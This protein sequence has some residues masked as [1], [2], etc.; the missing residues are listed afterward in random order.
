VYYLD[1]RKTY[2]P[3]GIHIEDRFWDSK[4]KQIKRSYQ[5][6]AEAQATINQLLTKI[7]Q[8]ILS[9]Q[10]LGE[11]IEIST[12]RNIITS[13]KP[14]RISLYEF[15]DNTITERLAINKTAKP[16]NLVKVKNKPIDY[17]KNAKVKLDFKDIDINFYY[18]FYKYF[19]EQGYSDNYFGSIIQNLK[20]LLHDAV[21]RK[22]TPYEEFKNPGF[23]VIEIETDAVYLTEKE[24]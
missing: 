10:A 14:S 2:L 4:N 13:N 11:D 7:E 9:R 16:S 24:L 22:V 3:T 12:I 15:L 6:Y 17:Q 19:V 23:K 21:R 20:T 5:S 18:S 8:L 1:G